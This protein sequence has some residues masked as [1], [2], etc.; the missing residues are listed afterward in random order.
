MLYLDEINFKI[1]M[2]LDNIDIIRLIQVK[3]Y[4][5]NLFSLTNTYFWKNKLK[6]TNLDYE[7]TVTLKT[8]NYVL[9][10]QKSLNN[11]FYIEFIKKLIKKYHSF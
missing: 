3:R 7:N 6:I 8:D 1:G 4:Y 9:S 11:D 5:R 2:F 10:F